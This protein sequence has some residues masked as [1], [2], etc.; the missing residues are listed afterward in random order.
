MWKYFFFLE[1]GAQ[2]L[3][4]WNEA[5]DYRSLSWQ[6][7]ESGSA[8]SAV[9]VYQ[10][11]PGSQS[12]AQSNVGNHNEANYLKVSRS[13]N[14]INE[15]QLLPKNELRISALEVYY[16]KVNTKRESMFFF[17]E[18]RLSFALIF[19]CYNISICKKEKLKDETS[20][21]NS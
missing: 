1:A 13:R 12:V 5:L 16:I 3:L 18:D 19:N 20:K 21:K 8:T 9:Y 14:K 6:I 4:C 2:V 11:K 15:L 10:S 17:Q 7:V